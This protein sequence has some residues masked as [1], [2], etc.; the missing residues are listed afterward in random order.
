MATIHSE[1]HSDNAPPAPQA[2]PDGPHDTAEQAGPGPLRVLFLADAHF[3]DLPG[4]SRVVARELARELIGRGHEV[5][6]LVARHA[7]GTPDDC[8]LDGVH[9]IRYSGAGT[10]LAFL[11][12]GRRACARLWAEKPFDV[13]HTHFAYAALGPLRAV[14]R[15]VPRIRTFHGPWDEEGWL[16]DMSSIP[17]HVGRLKAGIKRRMRRRVEGVS[18]HASDAIIT[19]SDVFRSKVIQA[20][21]AAE[22]DVYEISGGT[23]V[24][25]FTPAQN[26]ADVRR[27]LGLPVD[28][29]LLLSVRRLAPR[30]GLDNLIKAMPAIIARRP[31]AL[32]LIGG[33]GPERERLQQLVDQNGLQNHVRLLG[34]IPDEQLSAYY[35]AANL[36]VLPTLALEGF[37]LVTTEA[38]ASGV[39]V[40]GTPVG[41]TPE[42]LSLLDP[43]LVAAGTTPANLA[44]AVLGVLES[45]W[46]DALTPARLHRFVRDHYTWQRHADA[47]ETLYYTL[48][49]T[50]TGKRAIIYSKGTPAARKE[51]F[52]R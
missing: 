50:A 48:V 12:E 37:G 29:T 45:D 30:M 20:H 35:Q 31:D 34:F 38:L 27:A 49:C 24:E 32:L 18:L 44:Q 28:R 42:I 4:G 23:D 47:V 14:P 41:A 51:T 15:S 3:D 8:V 11:R 6:F 40:I 10:P 19:L 26:R 36:F 2:I 33:K 46:A 16:E 13:V 39:P 9:V 25:R 43:R 7:P 22:K 1:V 21:G 52:E 5:T 17:S